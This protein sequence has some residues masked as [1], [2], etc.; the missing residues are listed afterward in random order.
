M[1][2]F[3]T[4]P[5]VLGLFTSSAAN[6]EYRQGDKL[7]IVASFNQ[8]LAPGSTMTLTLN[9]GVEH[10]LSTIDGSSLR[11]VYTIGADQTVADL[12]VKAIK[13]AKI[14]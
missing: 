7:E 8:K 4:V 6:G 2:Y 3:Y 12:S 11:G 13:S 1:S 5:P 9:N 10:T 14:L